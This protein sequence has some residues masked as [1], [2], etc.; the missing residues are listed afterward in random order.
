M[1]RI[2]ERTKLGLWGK[3][4]RLALTDVG[5]I[6]RG[7]KAADID[8]MERMLLE[9]DLGIA[10]TTDL[11]GMLEDGVRRGT[12]KSE[13]DL[14][15]ALSGRLA[16]ILTG[17]GDPGRIARAESGPTVILVIGVNGVGKTTSIAKL[18]RRLQREGERVLL[19]AADTYRAGAIAQ[20]TTW[21]ERLG[22]PCVSGAPGGDPA[23]VA[24][25]G[26]VAAEARGATMVIVDTAG[27]LHTQEGLM[28]E[29]RKVVRVIARKAPGAPHETLLVLDG[30]VGQNA[31]QQGKL[32]SQAVSPTGLIVTKLDGTARG[33]AVVALRSELALPI[34]FLG[35]GETPDDL[36]VFDAAA[37]AEELVGDAEG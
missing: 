27:R 17:P 5:A 6:V 31:V 30:T 2:T 21:A 1:D 11:V 34:R 13:D 29:L 8:A 10:A 4:K 14:R 32:F 7:F 23:S 9:A 33:G 19:V 3:I 36:Q 18:A 28:E 22:V 20:L 12:F 37:F 35:T 16:Q 25:D 26:I 24:F 15:R